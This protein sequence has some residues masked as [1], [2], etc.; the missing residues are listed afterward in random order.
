MK[1]LV[2]GCFIFFL[3]LL[4]GLK[5]FAQDHL[6]SQFFNA[7]IYLNPA[8]TGQF[9]GDL[10]MNLIYRNQWT[11]VPGSLSYISASVDYNVPRFGGG[12][13]LIFTRSSEGTA[14]LDKTNISGVYS[15]SVGS[16]DYVLSFGL[17]AG[18]TNRVID[19]GK[20]VFGDQI[21][22]TLGVTGG[23]SAAGAL[24]Y[25]NK[26]YFD[27]G[28]GTNLVVGDFNIGA[29]MQHLNKP[30]E[31]FTGTPS[32]LPIRTNAHLSYRWDLNA[33][34]NLE[35][36]EK[37]YV[38]PSVVFYK[39]S[40][41]QSYDV[42]LQ[43][44]R[45]SIN[46]GLWYRGGGGGNGPGTVVVSLIFDL[47]INRDGGEKLRFGVSHDAPLSG[48]T[49]G[50]TSGTSEGSIGYETTLPSRGDNSQRFEGARRCYEFY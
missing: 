16:E 39:Q 15:Y 27:S 31:S 18:I 44:K 45:K 20:L 47:F 29:A 19:Y 38:I 37:A 34:D 40:N 36:D 6:Y 1:N 23:S 42:G 26:F 46:V 22:P 43:Y 4:T 7:P 11:S 24:P 32:K 25:N 35:E 12:I 28:I 30:N 50:N 33:F 8:L 13:G 14:Y 17:Q 2:T 5:S 48:L 10:R 9:K 3:L 49:Y 21:D 41:V